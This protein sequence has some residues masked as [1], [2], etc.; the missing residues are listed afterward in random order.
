[1]EATQVKLSNG[2]TASLAAT[3]TLTPSEDT[4]VKPVPVEIKKAVVFFIGGA[5]DKDSYYLT[6]PYNNIEQAKK[7]F[8]NSLA[9]DLLVSKKYTSHYLGY[10]EVKGDKDINKYVFSAIPSKSSPIYIVGHSLGG[11]NGAHLS[12][13][14]SEKGYIVSIL[15]TLDPVGEGALVWL[16]SDIYKGKPEPKAEFWIN[17]LAN[18]K[19]RDASDNVANFGSQWK[20][21]S[22]PQANYEVDTNH[23]RAAAMFTAPLINGISAAEHIYRSIKENAGTQ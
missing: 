22:G 12:K 13:I 7:Y 6:G 16:G 11:W 17:I 20:I 8:D 1:M 4:S 2:N 3:H 9:N 18:P 19:N 14:L 10:N 5:G 21:T 15:V 23:A